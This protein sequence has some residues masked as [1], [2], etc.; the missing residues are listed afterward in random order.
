[1][2][3]N[4]PPYIDFETGCSSR[5]VRPAAIGFPKSDPP[6]QTVVAAFTLA[7]QQKLEKL[8]EVGTLEPHPSYP[9][10]VGYGILY[11]V[12][13]LTIFNAVYILYILFI[14]FLAILKGHEQ[15]DAVISSA[16][17]RLRPRSSSE[18]EPGA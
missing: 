14:L 1:M 8:L 3:R 6:K 4:R 16:M 17:S 5:D 13:S 12:Y 10:T 7:K 9:H 15:F 11:T 18:V 2:K